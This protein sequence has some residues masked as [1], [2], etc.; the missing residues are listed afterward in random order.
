[1]IYFI[2][3]VGADA[4]KIG[5]T[6]HED[7]DRRVK[8]IQIASPFVIRMLGRAAGCRRVERGLHA[9]FKADRLRGEWFRKSEELAR[10]AMTEEIPAEIIE[11]AKPRPMRAAVASRG[12]PARVMLPVSGECFH[13]ALSAILTN[14][15]RRAPWL[16]AKVDVAASSVA[17][18]MEGSTMPTPDKL[19]AI[20]AA[21]STDGVQDSD[22]RAL[23]DAYVGRAPAVA[24]VPDA[25]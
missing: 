11:A 16:A 2:E 1:M 24:G 7:V 10:I 5:F 12:G 15:E 3:A 18:W 19:A 22:L 4:V 9:R 20:R 13:H 6:K 14:R 23:D 21:L 8:Q 17:R 25:P